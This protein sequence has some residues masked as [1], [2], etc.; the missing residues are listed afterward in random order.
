MAIF[1]R[2][3]TWWTDFSVNGQ[4]YRHS[5]HTTDWREAQAQQK[6]LITRASQGKLAPSS[7]QFARLRFSEAL[8]RY[9]AD[10]RPRVAARSHRSESDHARPLRGSFGVTPLTRIST[11]TILAYIRERK[12]GGISNTTVNMEIGILRRVLKRARRWHIVADDIRPLPERRD[13]GRAMSPDEKLRLLRE[14]ASRP[15]WQ[16]ARCATILALNTTMRG[17]EIRELRWSDIDLLERTVTIR[18]SKTR[19]GER[20][21]PLNGDAFAIILELAPN[22]CSP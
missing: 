4:R 19:A 14:A 2:G 6:E 15:E 16:V 5:L 9:L 21:I 3:K 17:C 22:V 7:Q 1:K 12:A 8:D 18:R 20:V 10:R 11:D 13:I